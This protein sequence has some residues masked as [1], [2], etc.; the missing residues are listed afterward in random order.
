[1][2]NYNSHGEDEWK[3]SWFERNKALVDGCGGNVQGYLVPL[4]RAFRDE[5][6]HNYI[7]FSIFACKELDKAITTVQ[8]EDEAQGKPR[9]G[10]MTNGPYGCA[11]SVLRE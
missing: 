6:H 3:E 9:V 8:T 7:W 10:L 2:S 1:M 5:T 4:V 11:I